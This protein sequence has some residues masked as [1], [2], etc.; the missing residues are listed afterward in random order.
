MLLWSSTNWHTQDLRCL[1]ILLQFSKLSLRWSVGSSS[2]MLE[3]QACDCLHEGCLLLSWT[4]LLPL[5]W[6]YSLYSNSHFSPS[7]L[8]LKEG[9][10]L[11]DAARW[12][13][14]A[15]SS[16][17]CAFFRGSVMKE[18]RKGRGVWTCSTLSRK[19][20]IDWCLSRKK[21]FSKVLCSN[22]TIIAYI[23]N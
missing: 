11:K 21:S 23:H 4:H 5:P 7:F 18:E 1:M 9:V 12:A 3:Y 16:V 20:L 15:A 8:C 19:W 17:T 10:C 22:V 13:I 6:P 2:W 14:G